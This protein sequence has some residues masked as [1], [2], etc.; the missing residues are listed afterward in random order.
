MMKPVGSFVFAAAVAGLLVLTVLWGGETE[1]RSMVGLLPAPPT[2]PA[3]GEVVIPT[4]PGG[5]ETVL[6]ACVVCHSV[7][8][9]DAPRAAPDLYG[10]VGAEKAASPWFNYSQALRSAEGV[11]SEA[12]LDEYLAHPPSFL[13]GTKKTI[14]GIADPAQRRDVI[15]ALKATGTR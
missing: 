9:A 10:I 12:D 8:P 2:T 13:P 1:G 7:D 6:S 4:R 15:D 14:V 5:D 11:W 3:L